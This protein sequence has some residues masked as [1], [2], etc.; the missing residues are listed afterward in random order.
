MPPHC[1]S[2]DG[3]VVGAAREALKAGDVAIVLPFVPDG[4]EE[5]VRA[6][7][8]AVMPV[9]AMGHQARAVADRLFFETVVRIHR[10]GEGA[11]YTGLKPAGSTVVAVHPAQT[12]TAYHRHQTGEVR[13]RTDQHR[14][15]HPR[16]RAARVDFAD[17]PSESVIGNP[18]PRCFRC[19]PHVRTTM[20]GVEGRQSNPTWS[21][22]EDDQVDLI[23]DERHQH[24]DHPGVAPQLV[25]QQGDY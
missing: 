6:A 22:A 13:D 21:W 25:A 17:E 24:G 4:D 19:S 7:F 18:M 14:Q 3:P 23:G 8:T 20:R 1:N 9:R 15:C 10:S 16:N 5:D 2:L 11:P 12:A